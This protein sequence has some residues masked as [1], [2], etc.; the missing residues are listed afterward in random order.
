MTAYETARLFVV[1]VAIYAVPAAI[2]WYLVDRK[3]KV[4]EKKLFAATEEIL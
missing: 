4:M 1:I 2:Y 3:I